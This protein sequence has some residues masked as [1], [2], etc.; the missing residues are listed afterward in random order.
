MDLVDLMLKTDPRQRE[1]ALDIAKRARDMDRKYNQRHARDVLSWQMDILATHVITP[2][3]LIDLR[4]AD[5][6]NFAHDLFGI[7][8]H[9]D[10]NT[11]RM[12][13][14]FLPRFTA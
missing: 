10:R 2:L 6:A 14:C 11:G 3:R 9:L 8:R 4:D 7:A 12:Q 1:I 5:D 13:D